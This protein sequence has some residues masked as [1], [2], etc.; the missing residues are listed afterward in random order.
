MKE[1]RLSPS[2]HLRYLKA[3][4]VQARIASRHG[5]VP[6]GA[7]VVLD[8]RVVGTGRNE[9]I[10]RKDPSAHAEILAIRKAAQ[11]LQSERL[12]GCILYSTL[13]P[14]PMCAGAAV[15]ARL[16]EVVYGAADPRAGACGSAMN[17]SSHKKLNHHFKV[18]GPAMPVE[19]G[20][21]LRKF[22]RKKRK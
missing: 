20:G 15:L 18:A 13:E 8:G 9:M 1:Q 4:L 22:F 14:C 19:C 17:L 10:S 2:R 21:I 3:A 6:V 5:E 11:K 7:V 16:S 12:P